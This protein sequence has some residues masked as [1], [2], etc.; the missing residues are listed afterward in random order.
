M[1]RDFSRAFYHSKEWKLT[2]EY[3]L[4]RDNYLCNKCG[5]PAQEV[6]HK[7]HLTPDNINDIAISLNP[8][9]LVS[10]C[11]ECHFKEHYR[12][13]AD[14]HRTKPKDTELDTELYVFD[15]FGQLIR[16]Q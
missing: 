3:I 12:D 4:K 8:S 14:G 2:R 9:N 15:E 16:K 7:I 11:K 5:M 13:K 1:A 6:H 10:L